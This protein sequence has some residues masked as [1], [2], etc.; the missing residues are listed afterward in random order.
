MMELNDE[1]LGALIDGALDDQK[2]AAVEQALRDDP[3]ARLRVERL[4]AADVR[5]REAF[6]LSAITAANPLARHILDGAPLPATT[7]RP[8]ADRTRRQALFAAA[9]AA[10]VCGV[11]IGH[12]ASLR[13]ARGPAAAMPP[14]AAAADPV[15]TLALES[16]RSGDVGEG[17]GATRVL[18]SF[19][20]GDGR[21]CRVYARNRARGAE[22]GVACRAGEQWQVVAFDRTVAVD[23]G[24][25]AAGASELIDGAMDRLGGG[26]AIDAAEE[27][28]LIQ[29]QWR[30][31]ESE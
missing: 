22:E 21:Y 12:W 26:G 8:R 1:I 15:L 14:S 3:G 10:G 27:R 9:L 24:F 20:A 29:R 19:R 25:H 4:R 30:A 17:L 31:P 23:R 6:A 7:L 13:L 16:S 18:L 5:I 2:R 11:V 28:E